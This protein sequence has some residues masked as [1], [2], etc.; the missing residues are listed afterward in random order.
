METETETETE[1]EME[2]ETETE[3]ET[4]TETETETSLQPLEPQNH[5]IPHSFSKIKVPF[6]STLN[7][8]DLLHQLVQ[9]L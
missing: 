5:V 9:T 4:E 2:T 1:M 8:Q 6:S 3:M 7:L